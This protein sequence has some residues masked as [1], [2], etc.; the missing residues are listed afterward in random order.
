MERG[1]VMDVT[2]GL[3]AF[4][5]DLTYDS[6]PSE[7]R[8]RAKMFILDATGVMLGGVALHETN[9]DRHLKQFM[10][11]MGP[12]GE[13]TIVGYQQRTTPMLAAFANGNLSQT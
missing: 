12:P 2:A 7:I 13:A 10:E 9:G 6:L 1:N 4:A 3:A 8:E 5:A 11:D